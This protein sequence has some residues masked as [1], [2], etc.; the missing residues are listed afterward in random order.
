MDHLESFLP[1]HHDAASRRCYNI[2]LDVA[3][4]S[5]SSTNV[6]APLHAPLY[7]IHCRTS[8]AISSI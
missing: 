6:T 1:Y 8:L 7:E 4:S 3:C 2:L 5:T